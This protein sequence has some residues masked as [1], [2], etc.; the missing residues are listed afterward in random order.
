MD[1]QIIENRKKSRLPGNVGILIGIIVIL[2]PYGVAI[3]NPIYIISITWIVLIG[4]ESWSYLLLIPLLW[5]MYIPF[6]FFRFMFIR[7]I[8][9]FYRGELKKG[10]LIK[11]GILADSS[12]VIYGSLDYIQYIFDP[13]HIDL[14]LVIPIPLLLL[15]GWL[16]LKFFPPQK[17]QEWIKRE[18][19]EGWWPKIH[20]KEQ[21]Q[22][23]TDETHPTDM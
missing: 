23:N 3:T 11:V 17:D 16:L 12:I 8:M 22:E 9:Q 1:S 7:D 5:V 4:S 19:D 2:A 15:I 21:D 18:R 13:I 20:V 14:E 6:T 10:R